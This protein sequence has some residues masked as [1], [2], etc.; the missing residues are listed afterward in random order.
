[1]VDHCR[2][3]YVLLYPPKLK[4]RAL[5]KN[6]AP[7]QVK[8]V[9]HHFDFTLEDG[10]VNRNENGRHKEEYLDYFKMFLQA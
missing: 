3:L 4:I 5:E 1:M 7:H 6:P 10:G 8:G 9:W 2:L